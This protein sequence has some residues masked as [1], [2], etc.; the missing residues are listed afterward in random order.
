MTEQLLN[1]AEIGAALQQVRRKRVAQRVRADPGSGARGRHVAADDAVDAAHGEAAAPVVDEERIA[2]ADAGRG[3]RRAA[4]EIAAQRARRARIERHEPLFPSFPEHTD[5]LAGEVD[6]I[7]S[8][9]RELAHA[10]A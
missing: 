1:H 2:L 3:G 5:H 4:L 9:T 6:V 10:Q 7:E 8:E